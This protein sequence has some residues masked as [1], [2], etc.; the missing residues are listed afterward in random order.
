MFGIIYITTN[1]VNGKIYIG[2]DTKN[3]GLG[4]PNYLGS[5]ILLDLAVKKYGVENFTKDVLCSC[6]SL[7]DLKESEAFYIRKY[8]ANKRNIG[9]NISNGYWGGDTLSEHPNLDLIR[10]KI[11]AKSKYYSNEISKRNKEFYLK[12]SEQEKEI[13]VL[14][15]KKSMEKIDKSFFS[16]PEYL[17]R[18]SDGIKN[19][20]KFKEYTRNR[21]GMKRGKYSLDKE[22]TKNKRFETVQLLKDENLKSLLMNSIKLDHSTFSCISQVYLHIDEVKKIPGLDIFISFIDSSIFSGNL[23]LKEISVEYKK[24][25]L[26]KINLGKSTT[27]VKSIYDFKEFGAHPSRIVGASRR[28]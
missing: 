9:Y 1:R 21:I 6:D 15:I 7:E 13:R 23:T 25:G 11:R 18:L 20:E 10:E 8:S 28:I 4:D 17:S 16:D 5:G 12:E 19:S 24:I 2:S 3:L 26:D 22:S 14:N 27:V